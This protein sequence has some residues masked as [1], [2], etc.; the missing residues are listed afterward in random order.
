MKSVGCRFRFG[1]FSL[2]EPALVVVQACRVGRVG[3]WE[4]YTR[5]EYTGV[6]GTLHRC[7][8]EVGV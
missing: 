5:A 6:L 2:T 8:R 1:F 4:L 7:F 3:E